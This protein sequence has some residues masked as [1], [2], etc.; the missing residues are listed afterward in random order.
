MS[1][2]GLLLLMYIGYRLLFLLFSLL[3]FIWALRSGQF[4]RPEHTARL[5]LSSPPLPPEGTE[6]RQHSSGS[7]TSKED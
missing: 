5:P 2:S 4:S 3:I 1:N 6:D 7:G